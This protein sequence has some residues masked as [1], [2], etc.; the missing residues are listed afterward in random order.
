MGQ[1]IARL[2]A[3]RLDLDGVDRMLDVGGGYGHYARALCRVRPSL[4]ADVLDRPEVVELARVGLAGD[5]LAG[6]VRFRGGDYTT[7]DFG[8]GYDLVLLANVLHQESTGTAA[9]LVARA[10]GALAPGG[11]VAVLDFAIDDEQR[12]HVLGT[13]FAVNMRSFGHTYTAP[14][15]S[16]WLTRAGLEEIAR[17]D[18]NRH[19]WLI[20]GRRPGA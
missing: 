10:A 11:R 9:A 4:L 13:L 3:D 15:I 1:N 6:R 14:T 12:A 18:L 8:S 16:G 7:D 17:E 5:P 20:T 19:R 2:V